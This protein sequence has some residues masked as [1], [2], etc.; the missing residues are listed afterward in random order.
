MSG[1]AVLSLAWRFVTSR[2]GI[3]VIIVLALF[4]WHKVDKNSAVRRA[5]TGY[6]A[7]V[8][9]SARTAE[10]DELK[11]RSALFAI[12]NRKLADEAARAAAEADAANQELEHYVSTVADDC[13]V[14]AGL[15]G[16]LRNR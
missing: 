13:A 3:V 7:D 12:A 8:E 2:A 15:L 4:A 10:L 1:A 6:V 11:R 16:R 5:V 14:D 9:F